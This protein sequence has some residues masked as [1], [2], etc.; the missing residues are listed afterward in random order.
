MTETVKHEPG[1]IGHLVAAASVLVGIAIGC[2]EPSG[3]AQVVSV[4]VVPAARTL[5]ALSD[6]TR[7]RAVAWD[8][9]GDSI[10]GTQFVWASGDP[11]VAAI[12]PATGLVTAVANGTAV[13]WATAGGVSGTAE[14]MVQQAV[15]TIGVAS[16]RDT[17]RFYGDNV[18][19]VATAR[20]GLGNV[21]SSATFTWWSSNEPAVTVSGT[22]MATALASDTA[23]IRASSGGQ[24]GPV[25]VTASFLRWSFATGARVSTAPAVGADG[26]VYFG[27]PAY[28]DN[29][30]A[31]RPDGTVRWSFSTG[32]W[33]ES[34]AVG[35]AGA[36]YVSAHNLYTLSPDG[37][38]EWSHAAAAGRYDSDIAI[39]ADGTVYAA[40][41]SNA[42]QR[43]TLDAI[44]ADGTLRWSYDLDHY[45][46]GAPA[47]GA[48]GT[49]YVGC[50]ETLHALH[51]D[52]TLRWSYL[53]AGRTGS[54][55]VGADGTVYVGASDYNLYALDADGTLRWSYPTG[56]IPNRSAAVATDGTVLVSSAGTLAA[57]NPDGTLR[58][59][60]VLGRPVVSALGQPTIGTG[61]AVFVASHDTLY[62][63]DPDGN[64][65]W[66]YPLTDPSDPSWGSPRGPMRPPALAPGGTL[67]AGLR[68]KGASYG[69]LWPINTGLDGLAKAP[70]PKFR[71]DNRN[72]ANV[73]TQ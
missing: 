71:H 73:S 52:G 47:I 28:D 8:A 18:Q 65:Q 3:P 58:W 30:Y 34:V 19:L 67:Y 20:D 41:F 51:P 39:G 43:Y 2:G 13:I 40:S 25:V 1:S 29:V 33:V 16:P 50:W 14:V 35:A 62:A 61:G 27:L 70:W 12:D 15:A 45:A 32:Y 56:S 37:A 22:G 5:S 42:Q 68:A 6:T 23:T 55:A 64:R 57:L 31:L 48:D 10:P 46:R 44:N 38:L 26:T 60:R 7:F 53:M 11:A 66:F 54:P 49:V 9:V 24:T 63:L 59:S 69:Y 17:L 4:D 36:V 21:V 72:T